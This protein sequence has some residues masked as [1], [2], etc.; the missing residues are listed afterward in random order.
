MPLDSESPLRDKHKHVFAA[1]GEKK[2]KERHEKGLLTPASGSRTSSSPIPSGGTFIR[3]TC[4]AFDM[5]D[6]DLPADGVIV[7]SGY[8][9]GRQARQPI[10]V[11]GY[12]YLGLAYGG[13]PFKGHQGE[14]RYSHA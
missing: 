5:A 3:H 1:G 11:A 12:L 13:Y 6:K 7:S 2:T 14:A 10:T 9:N 4:T 8:V